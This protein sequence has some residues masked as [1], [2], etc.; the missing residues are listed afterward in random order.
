MISRVAGA[1]RRAS[2]YSITIF[3]TYACSAGVGAAMVHSGNRFALARRD[4]IVAAASR[5][6]ISTDYRAGRRYRAALRDAAANFGLAALPQTVTGLTIVM[7]YATVSRQGWIGGIVSVDGRHASRLRSPRG[8]SYYVGVLLLQ[9]LAFS[10]C[11]GGGVR[12]GVALY[13]E[14]REVGW[15]FWRYRLART[16]VSDLAL[17]V[18]A[19]VPLFLLASTFEFLVSANV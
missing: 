1:V 10:V 18:C 3:V 7:P 11:I 19:S 9:F 5:D 8:A 4:A 13:E 12:C 15:R 16:S 6:K 17:V 14:N 2:R